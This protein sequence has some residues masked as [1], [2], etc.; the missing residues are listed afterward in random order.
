MT[1]TDAVF[2]ASHPSLSRPRDHTPPRSRHTDLS[3]APS[4]AVISNLLLSSCENRYGVDEEDGLNDSTRGSGRAGGEVGGSDGR[5]GSGKAEEAYGP[6]GKGMQ[7]IAAPRDTRG[8]NLHD[9][10]GDVLQSPSLP[11]TKSLGF[12]V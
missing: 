2:P 4:P 6:R 12:Y 1:R 8:R 3:P 5:D 9:G 10:V 11:T 7:D